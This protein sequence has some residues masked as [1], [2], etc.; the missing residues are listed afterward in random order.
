M[1][2]HKLKVHQ[3]PINT[4]QK[5]LH[6]MDLQETIVLRIKRERDEDI[7]LLTIDLKVYKE[8]LTHHRR[9]TNGSGEPLR[10]GVQIGSRVSGLCGGWMKISSTPLG[11]LEYW[12]IY[13]VKSRSRG[14]PRWAQ[15]TWARMGLLAPW[16][17]FTSLGLPPGAT[18]TRW[19]PS[20]P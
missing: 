4:P 2:D 17:V 9:G 6:H 5:E 11:F 19:V 12:R 20:D 7:Q 1:T 15:P 16:W 14:H 3:I 18:R 10:D 8:L 13:R